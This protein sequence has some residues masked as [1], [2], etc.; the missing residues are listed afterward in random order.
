MIILIKRK[1]I[2]IFYHIQYN[3]LIT[4]IKK[5]IYYKHSR[6]NQLPNKI[7]SVQNGWNRNLHPKPV[8]TGIKIPSSKNKCKKIKKRDGEDKKDNILKILFKIKLNNISKVFLLQIRF[9]I[10]GNIC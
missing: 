10:Y 2:Q 1:K 9:N 7:K 3:K 4:N 8:K 5:K 6:Q